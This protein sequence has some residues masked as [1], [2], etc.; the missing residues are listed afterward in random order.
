MI[1]FRIFILRSLRKPAWLVACL[2]F[3]ATGRAAGQAGRIDADTMPQVIGRPSPLPW[4]DYRATT[5]AEG[6][7]R[8][9]SELIRARAARD[10]L[11]A[12]ALKAMAEAQREQI[13]A[14]EEWTHTF[15][16]LREANREYRRR[17]EA[18]RLTTED[19][20]RYSQARIPDR[21]GP[22]E[23]SPVTGELTWPDALEAAAFAADRER[24][25]HLFADWTRYGDLSLEDRQEIRRTT[26]RMHETLRERIKVLPP[27]DYLTALRFLESMAYEAHLAAG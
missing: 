12:E 6:H 15:F 2:V 17:E 23:F 4:V 7:A 13:R 14:R 10:R 24:L 9:L 5:P 27:A 22:E 3:A 16:R 8:G 18:P 21:L 20:V 25:E 11:S 26:E 1:V 19:V